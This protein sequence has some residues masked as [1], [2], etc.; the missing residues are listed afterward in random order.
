MPH[1]GLYISLNDQ[2]KIVLDKLL[3]HILHLI[4]NMATFAVRQSIFHFVPYVWQILF[5]LL[6][7]GNPPPQLK[8]IRRYPRLESLDYMNGKTRLLSYQRLDRGA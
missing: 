2:F 7:L 6:L 5:S 3:I 4:E 1:C 8:C